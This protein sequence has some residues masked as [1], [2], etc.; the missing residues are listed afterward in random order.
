L[1]REVFAMHDLIDRPF[2]DSG[3]NPVVKPSALESEAAAELSSRIRLLG[4]R[5]ELLDTSGKQAVGTLIGPTDADSEMTVTIMVRSK[6]SEKQINETLAAVISHRLKPMSAKEFNEKFGADRQSVERVKKF[7]ADNGLTVTETNLDS[8]RLVIKGKVKNIGDAFQVKLNDYQCGDD[9]VR[10]RTGTVSVPAEIGTDV[11]AVLG[12]DS[13]LQ[14][15]ALVHMQN[16]EEQEQKEAIHIEQNRE[17]QNQEGQDP[18]DRSL[19]APRSARG[20][21][22]NQVADAYDFPKESMGKGQSVGIIELGGGLDLGDNAR[23]YKDHGLKVPDIQVVGVD[24][25]SSKPG[26]AADDEVALDSQVIGAVAPEA[27]QQLVFAPPTDQGFVDA[28]TRATFAAEGEKQNSAISISWGGRESSW[29]AQTIK[30]MD[31][32]FRK[33]ALKGISVFAASGDSGAGDLAHNQENDGKFV[34][35]F[36]ASD[37]FVTAAGG[38]RLTLDAS[39]KPKE[40]AWN[41]GK[42]SSGGG[43]VSQIFDPPEYQKGLKIKVDPKSGERAGRGVPDVAGDASPATGY[44]V[45]VHGREQVA[46]GTSAV[47]PLYAALVMRINGALGQSV[48]F[49]NPFLY[50]HGASRIFNDVTRGSNNGYSAGPGWDAATGWGSI[51]GRELLNQLRKELA[52]RT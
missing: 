20:F 49:L 17:G 29:D 9:V 10:E 2:R 43:G 42:E 37:P 24:G 36:P 46:G 1:N 6:A 34:A 19:V 7:A 4:A 26:S 15:K 38:T 39:G 22:P 48:G 8:G 14:T 18:E 41:D 11:Q 32:A 21:M 3:E 5:A 28:I 31:L 33:A 30:A 52:A 27:H 35:D 45:R 13:K 16:Q 47:A 40:V 50:K 12:L 23:Y 44:R 51:R 25:A